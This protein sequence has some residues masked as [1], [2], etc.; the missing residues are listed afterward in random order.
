MGIGN[1]LGH[2]YDDVAETIVWET[3]RKR[4]APL[5]AVVAAEIAAFESES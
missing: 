4:L 2:D 5:L 1:V 3:V